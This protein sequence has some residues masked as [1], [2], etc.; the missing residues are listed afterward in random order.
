M[1]ITFSR[2]N[3]AGFTRAYYLV[4]RKS[5]SCSRRSRLENLKV[6]IIGVCIYG[7]LSDR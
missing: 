4:L 5:C 1:I 2:Q 6:S 3:D 7:D